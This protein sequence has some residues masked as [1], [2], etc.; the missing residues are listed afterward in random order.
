MEKFKVKLI[1]YTHRGTNV[2]PIYL[3]VYIDG[4]T[5]YKAT[6][7]ECALIDWDK[8]T[9]SVRNHKLASHINS[10]ITLKKNNLI[11]EII[12]QGIAGKVINI[13]ATM[14]GKP[15]TDIFNFVEQFKKEIVNKRSPATIENY[16]KHLSKLVEFNGSVTLAFEDITPAYLLKYENWLRKSVGNNYTHKLIT[17]LR[18]FFNAAIK[19]N[20]ITCYPFKEYEFPVYKS[21]IKDYLTMKELKT[22][23]DNIPEIESYAVKQAA[24]YFLFGCYSGLRISDWF[25]FNKSNVQGN[26]IR[27]TTKKTG[28]DVSMMISKPL[29]RVLTM[30]KKTPLAI[31]EPTINEKLKVYAK[32]IK[33]HKHI[34][35]HSAR[36]SFAITICL[37]NKISS[38]TAAELMGITLKTFVDNY[39]QVNDV[40][41][42]RETKEAWASLN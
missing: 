21:P 33:I 36:H 9:E 14:S 31:E 32:K 2:H 34:T 20:L 8:K 6:G 15:L 38:E 1:L 24:I 26:R 13:K 27:L 17:T 42:D 11:K 39:S 5:T 7:F 30:I 37:E 29:A 19:R 10:E 3:R 16:T 22:W 41:I 28:T 35:S 25:L 18:T 23:E 12:E 4:K 40:K